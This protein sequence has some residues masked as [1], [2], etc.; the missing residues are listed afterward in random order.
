MVVVMHG[1]RG[2]VLMSRTGGGAERSGVV[3]REG[4]NLLRPWLARGGT[5]AMNCVPPAS[6]SRRGTRTSLER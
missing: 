3:Q 4:H 6:D 2:S 5:D 1:L